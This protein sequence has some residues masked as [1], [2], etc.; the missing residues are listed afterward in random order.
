MATLD[1]SATHYSVRPLVVHAT[2]GRTVVAVDDVEVSRHVAGYVIEQRMGE[3]PVVVL[4][5]VPGSEGL[6]EFDGLARVAVGVPPDPGPAAAAFLEAIDPAELERAALAR[7]DLAGDRHGLTRAML[8]QL[9]EW[10]R[11]EWG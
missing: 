4:H 10:A 5:L 8:D 7:P 6:L 11:G 9:R 1:S 2:G 3:P